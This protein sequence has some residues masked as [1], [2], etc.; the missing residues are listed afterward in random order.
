MKQIENN[1]VVYFKV[2]DVLKIKDMVKLFID[3]F[4]KYLQYLINLSS[5]Y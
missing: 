3:H 4:N 2:I 5:V 1:V